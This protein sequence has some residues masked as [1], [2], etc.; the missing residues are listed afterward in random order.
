MTLHARVVEALVNAAHDL[1]D[2]ECY[3]TAEKYR[4]LASELQDKA[5]VPREPTE[6]M[7][8]AIG[9]QVWRETGGERVVTQAEAGAVFRAM[10]QAGESE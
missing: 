1:D 2:D 9:Q 8:F 10:L 4:A 5:I 6:K 3:E 7:L